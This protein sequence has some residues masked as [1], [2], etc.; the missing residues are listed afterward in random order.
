MKRDH[1]IKKESNPNNTLSMNFSEFSDRKSINSLDYLFN[2][3][4]KIYSEK[5]LLNKKDFFLFKGKNSKF[6]KN[7]LLLGKRGN[8]DEDKSE[9]C[10][11][12]KILRPDVKSLPL[13]ILEDC[14][15]NSNQRR[16]K[17]KNRFSS[18]QE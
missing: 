14:K 13:Y 8:F 11:S 18:F 4:K 6:R 2:K 1:S 3:S 10:N 9:C 15:F 12:I 7:M 16:P 17:S 5:C